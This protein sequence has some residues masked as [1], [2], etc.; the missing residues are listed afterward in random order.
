MAIFSDR[1]FWVE[2]L[3]EKLKKVLKRLRIIEDKLSIVKEV[4]K[5]VNKSP[6]SAQ[7]LIELIETNLDGFKKFRK[8]S[9]NGQSK[10]LFSQRLPRNSYN[11]HH[12]SAELMETDDSNK[13]KMLKASCQSLASFCLKRVE[14]VLAIVN[15]RDED[16]GRVYLADAFINECSVIAILFLI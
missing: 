9:F 8:S 13:L 12:I 1:L 15:S 10:F 16:E 5:R 3:F 4:S 14:Q 7:P 6:I 11:D 2:R